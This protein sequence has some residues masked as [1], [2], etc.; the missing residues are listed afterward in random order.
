MAETTSVR[1]VR[2]GVLASG[3]G[4]NLQA[5]LDAERDGLLRAVVAVVISD[6]PDAEALERA[7]R[8]RVAAV[9]LDPG[10]PR[11]RLRPEA[12]GA[13]V[14][15][16]RSHGVDWVVLAGYFRIVGAVLLGA[17]PHRVLN[18]HPSLLPSFPG[19]HGPGQALTY[20]VRVAGCT[21]HLVTESVDA[22]PILAQAAVEVRSD[23]TEERLAAR[24]LEQEHRLLS[25]TVNAVA[26]RAFFIDG[27]TVRWEGDPL[28]TDDGRE[29]NAR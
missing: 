9:H 13:I 2:L 27:R 28:P 15:T 17:F 11:V 19:L 5:L 12:E 25:E 21:V 16:L 29:R 6:R 14:D 20:G 1:P 18:I 26:T 23:D 24:I 7:R 3:R 4:S 8:H 10:S 22:G